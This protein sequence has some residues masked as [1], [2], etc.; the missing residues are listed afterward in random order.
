V[1]SRSDAAREIVELLPQVAVNLRLASLFDLEAVDL[2]A[3]QMLALMLLR[4]APDGRMKAGEMA[5]RLGVSLPA[6]T[7]LAD[8]LVAAGVVERVHGAD[9]RVVWV[10]VTNDG[11]A[12]INRLAEGLERRIDYAIGHSDPRGL[13]ALVEGMRTVASFSDLVGDPR[14]PA[15]PFETAPDGPGPP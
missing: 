13:D 8:R 9:R 6:A 15:A 1:V 11:I 3:N 2:T 5:G 7:A 4:S 12:L 10:G 14:A